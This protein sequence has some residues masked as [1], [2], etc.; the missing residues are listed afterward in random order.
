VNR[1]KIY[2][3]GVC[4]GLLLFSVICFA[5]R[6]LVINPKIEVG[7]QNDSNF[8]KFEH[9]EVSVN[10]YY[11]KP[12]IVLGFETPRTQISL[13]ATLEPYWYDDQDSP[14]AGVAKA[15]DN[16]YT[17]F[18][19]IFRANYQLADRLNIGLKDQAYV[20]RDPANAD[21]NS[22]SVMRDK[23][24]I[25]YVEPNAYYKL[26]NKFGLRSAYRNTTTD[27]EKKLEDSS[28]N[29]GI[30]DLY[31]A[32][33]STSTVYLDY[34]IWARDYDQRSS[35]YTSNMVTLNY[36]RT[37]KY[38][39]FLGGAGYQHRGFEDDNLDNLD[40][41]TWKLQ[42]K[43]M[44]ADSTVKTTR[45]HLLL[46]IG[47]NMNDSGTGDEY[48]TA[49]YVRFEGSYR[50]T[51]WIEASVKT[52]YQNSNY[53]QSSEDDDTYLWSGKLA[54]KPLDYL[55]LGIEGGYKTRD[56]NLDGKTYDDTF[57][58]LSLAVDYDL[59]K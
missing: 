1:K 9:N 33:N 31:Y 55:T 39:S 46:E 52:K 4:I 3:V 47:Q 7:V 26:T 41:F 58:L 57:V 49:T 35:G 50:F 23:Y 16:N 59:G 28:E 17:G 36:K 11:A 43:R 15:S 38:F 54:Y 8:W 18:T 27:Y 42:I 13:D 48:Y 45:S 21:I 37:F 51:E 30:F 2:S 12:G 40:L 5:E 53:D 29:R 20:T 25:N 24:T 22:N 6:K 32:F 19:G 10:T 44:D 56:S 14:P 34:Q